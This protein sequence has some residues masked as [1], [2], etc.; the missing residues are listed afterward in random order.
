MEPF[1]LENDHGADVQFTGEKIAHVT[2]QTP[3]RNKTRWTVLDL[4]R[5]RGGKW[6]C[7]KIGMTM[8]EG[9]DDLY[10]VYTADSD[11][12]LVAQ[13]GVGRLAKELYDEAGIEHAE[14]IE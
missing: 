6:V 14:N 5:T 4:Y 10:T 7:H 13:V 11:A 12:D 2:S 3:G 1:I 8:W 9:E